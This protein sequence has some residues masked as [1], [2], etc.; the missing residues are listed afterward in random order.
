V[1]LPEFAD[2]LHIF[3]PGFRGWMVII[4]MSLLPLLV[5]QPVKEIHSKRK[6]AA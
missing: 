4:G 6:M 3:N 1:Y 5:G 2:I